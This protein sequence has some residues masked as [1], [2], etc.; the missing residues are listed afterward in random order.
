MPFLQSGELVVDFASPITILVGPNGCGKS[1]LLEAIAAHIGFNVNGGSRDNDYQAY[2]EG[3]PLAKHLKLIWGRKVTAGF[4]FRAESLSYFPGHLDELRQINYNT[5]RIWGKTPLMHQSHG[6]AFRT[7]FERRLSGD[8]RAVYLLDEPEAA[9]S[10]IRQLEFLMKLDEWRDSGIVQ[11]IIAT[12]SP[13]LMSC[14][15]AQVIE[16][17][18]RGL[19]QVDFRETAHYRVLRD[20]I[21]AQE[22]G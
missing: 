6:E 14:S 12:H 8:S 21:L 22:R 20:F 16:F 7:L 9:L 10:P 18:H 2:E 15:G 13:I 5:D 1:S 19:T 11:A 17:R 3:H 4:F